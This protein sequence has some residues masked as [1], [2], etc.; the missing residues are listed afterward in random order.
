M[1]LAISLIVNITIDILQVE[2]GLFGRMLIAL[3]VKVLFGLIAVSASNQFYR[4]NPQDY[5]VKMLLFQTGYRQLVIELNYYTDNDNDDDDSDTVSTFLT[6]SHANSENTFN[7]EPLKLVKLVTLPVS[8]ALP[9]A[10][11]PWVDES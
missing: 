1:N 10:S 5:S 8:T 7:R 6:G 2:L 4:E 11:R 3:I 9:D